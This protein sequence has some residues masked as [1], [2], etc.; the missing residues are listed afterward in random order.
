MLTEATQLRAVAAGS[1]LDA[2]ARVQASSK[3]YSRAAAPLVRGL[4]ADGGA[5]AA[6]VQDACRAL[7]QVVWLTSV[8]RETIEDLL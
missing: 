3:M 2:A 6:R 8:P 4:Q 7:L 5:A 1:H